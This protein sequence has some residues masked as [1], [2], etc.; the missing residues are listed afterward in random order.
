MLNDCVC[1][2]RAL[3]IYTQG[4]GYFFATFSFPNLLERSN[5]TDLSNLT[6]AYNVGI[7]ENELS[8]KKYRRLYII[9]HYE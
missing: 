1:Y 9:I 3:S 7:V 2:P 6:Q 5:E 4:F 8:G